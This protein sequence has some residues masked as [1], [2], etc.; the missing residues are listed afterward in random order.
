MST[1]IPTVPETPFINPPAPPEIPRPDPHAPGTWVARPR[2]LVYINGYRMRYPLQINITRGLDQPVG[3]CDLTFAY[4]IPRFLPTFSR[5]AVIIGVNDPDVAPSHREMLVRF[6]GYFIGEQAALWPGTR[7]LHCEDP[8][9]IAKVTYTPEPMDNTLETDDS[10]IRR[11]LGPPEGVQGGCGFGVNAQT[12]QGLGEVLG[13]VDEAHLYWEVD[14]SA[15]EYIDSIDAISLGFRTYALASGTIYR[16]KIEINPQTVG[17]VYWFQEGVDILDGSMDK[18]IL[19]PKNEITVEGFGDTGNASPDDED[20]FYWRRNTYWIRYLQLKA[21]IAGG[22][23]NPTTVAEWIQSQINR[24]IIKVT[25]STHLPIH[26]NS[27]EVIRLT[28][29]TLEVDQNMWVQSV[30][31][32]LDPTGQFTQTLTCI[33]ELGPNQRRTVVPPVEPPPDQPP[34]AVLPP[35]P[36]SPTIVPTAA[37]IMP[38]F[39]IEAIDREFASPAV[40]S[41]NR[42]QPIFGVLASDQSSSRQGTIA[43]RTW[44]AAGPGVV[45]TSGADRE[46]TTYF[47]DLTDASTIT[48]T[49]TDSNGSTGSLTKPAMDFG[50]PI[51]ARKLYSVTPE[52]Y[53]AYDGNEW[54]SQAPVAAD[55]AQVVGGGP[56]WGA[57]P[58][59]ATSD[60]DLATPAVETQALASGAEITAIWVH[61]EDEDYVAVGGADGTMAYTTDGAATWTAVTGP[62]NPINFVIVSIFNKL[63]WHVVTPDG[64]YKSENQGGTWELVRAGSFVYLELSHTRNIV[65]TTDGEL[66]QAETGTPFT[67]NSSPIVAATAHIRKDRFYALAEDGTTWIQDTDGS[68]ALL[69]GEPIPAGTPY[70]A[71]TY[72]DG[73]MVNLVY[74]AAQ[75]GGLFKTMDGFE[76]EDGYLRLRSVGLLTP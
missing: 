11:V 75:D 44:T 51:L 55:H 57:G 62:G 60:D 70:H 34:G 52:S 39:A 61:E 8:L 63:Q 50:T 56:Y 37:D 5:V 18:S 2:H 47:T 43:S 25:F 15:M 74:F 23:V 14:Q 59:V 1:F 66:Q 53:E 12:I 64:W 40:D 6:S 54:R 49:V 22:I 19:D 48:L 16:R 10:A 28:S 7:T 3:T 27:Q 29:P 67:G 31:I 58:F 42:G 73:L 24:P 36:V 21:A 38:D 71:G 72:R 17:F 45:M 20:P 46:F 69:P 4:P 68:F 9:S 33:S 32:T 35:Y 30:N 76:T 41:T 65:V 26:F 13:D